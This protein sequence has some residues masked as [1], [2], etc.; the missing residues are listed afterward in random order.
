MALSHRLELLE[1]LAQSERSVDSLAS[2]TGLSRANTSQHLQA[3]K[4][5]ALVETRKEGLFVHYATSATPSAPC[6]PAS[7]PI[8]L[9]CGVSASRSATTAGRRW[10]P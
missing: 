9:D 2:E 5:A 6:W 3:L 7:R 4:Q 10:C 8:A 1:L